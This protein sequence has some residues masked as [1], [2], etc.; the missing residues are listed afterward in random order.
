MK[1]IKNVFLNLFAFCKKIVSRAWVV[2]SFFLREIWLTIAYV[3]GRFK[4]FFTG[5]F[6]AIKFGKDKTLH[7]AHTIVDVALSKEERRKFLQSKLK[8]N[9]LKIFFE[10]CVFFI[11]IS[12]FGLYFF[13]AQIN[14]NNFKTAIIDAAQRELGINLTINGNIKWSVFKMYP[15]MEI[16]D[17]V[18]DNINFDN[19]IY[20]VKLGSVKAQIS[21]FSIIN[22]T[23]VISKIHLENIDLSMMQKSERQNETV[24]IQKVKRDNISVINSHKIKFDIK[25]VLLR[26]TL[27]KFKFG[28]KQD[29]FRIRNLSVQHI[30]NESQIVL[31][32]RFIYKNRNIFL[33]INTLPLKSWIDKVDEIPLNIRMVSLNTVADANLVL[34]NISKS[35]TYIGTLN[36]KSENLKNILRIAMGDSIHIGEINLKSDIIGNKTFA[37]LRNIDLNVANSDVSGDV[38]IAFRNRLK[39]NANLRSELIDLPN[40]FWPNWR[41]DLPES[42]S[43][44]DD[45]IGPWIAENR[46]PNAFKDT[47]LFLDLW[48]KFDAN[49]VIKVDTVKAMPQMPVSNID[50]AVLM[51]NGIA[52]IK[53]VSFDYANGSAVVNGFGRI[54]EE[55]KLDASVSVS[56]ENIDISKIIDYTGY[57][58]FMD[59]GNGQGK[60]FLKSVGADLSELMS[61]VS[62]EFKL[63]SMDRIR[64]KEMSGFMTGS[65]IILGLIDIFTDSVKKT[66]IRNN[67]EKSDDA[68]IECVVANGTIE[69]GI[70]SSG[71]GLVVETDTL[72]I[73]V[74]GSADLDQ[75]IIDMKM[76]TF[77][78]SGLQILNSVADMV[79]VSGNMSEPDVNLSLNG[80]T[81]SLVKTGLLTTGVALTGVGVA[82]IGIGFVAKAVWDN[83]SNEKNP[84]NRALMLPINQDLAQNVFDNAYMS[85]KIFD[86]NLILFDGELKNEKQIF[87]KTL[88]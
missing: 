28:N 3:F 75:E 18:I 70:Y 25:E 37:A 61:N 53:N 1:K 45:W 35:P 34:K 84:C 30:L 51:N 42:E 11:I 44:D 58:N 19:E 8:Q 17:V 6:K 55:K 31:S 14:P 60:V 64:V 36:I 40:I 54:T 39:I 29:E 83:I 23:N 85:R 20:S 65:D 33:S 24:N 56:T 21:L 74:D 68:F 81:S 82:A 46:L 72:N 52:A 12:L 41:T 27:I 66:V 88:Q 79:H 59:G 10:L 48:E 15:A 71:V 7:A 9:K 50:V 4:K 43:D 5:M 77:P 86:E 73:V 78:K 16:T 67:T 49:I 22:Q 63:H 76:I 47:P 13:I 62:G 80:T 26:D 87:Q 2:F 69:K 57:E 38:E 32:S